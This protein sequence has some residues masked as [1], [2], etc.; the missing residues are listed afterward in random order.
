MDGLVARKK[1]NEEKPC[2]DF[3]PQS[4]YKLSTDFLGAGHLA[5]E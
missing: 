5:F 2:R 3:S 1:I 4:F